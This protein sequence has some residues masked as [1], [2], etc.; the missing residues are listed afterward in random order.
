MRFH[1]RD[2]TNIIGRFQV[3]HHGNGF[4][5]RRSPA[6]G[7]GLGMRIEVSGLADGACLLDCFADASE[8][9]EVL[10]ETFGQLARRLVI[11]S[12]ILPSV[13]RI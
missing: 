4:L 7:A 10:V 1:F 9:V 2:D 8:L 3:K 11:S 13:P 6:L 5:Q 12:G